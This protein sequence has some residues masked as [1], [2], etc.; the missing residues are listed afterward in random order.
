M[1]RDAVK[2]ARAKEKLASLEAGGAPDRPL[3]VKSASVVEVMAK[4][5]PC[6]IC[7]ENVRVEEHT[8]EAIDGRPL[9][10]AHV[11]CV[12][13]GAKRTIW[14]RIGTTQPS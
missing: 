4:S 10:A 11:R 3:E 1:E 6:V 7:G 8:A 2:L 13:C 9:R 14:F 5:L 12:Q